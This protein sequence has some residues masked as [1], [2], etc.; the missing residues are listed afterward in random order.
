MRSVAV[1]P[2]ECQL[3]PLLGPA[4]RMGHEWPFLMSDEIRFISSGVIAFDS[5]IFSHFMQ[6]IRPTLATVL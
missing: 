3:T 6:L 4:C 1:V 5:L 2:I